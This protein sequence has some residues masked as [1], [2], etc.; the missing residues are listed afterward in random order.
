M[1]ICCVES[2]VYSEMS[3]CTSLLVVPSLF[4]NATGVTSHECAEL[5]YHRP[6]TCTGYMFADTCEIC[7]SSTKT[8]AEGQEAL[9]TRPMCHG[10]TCVA[11]YGDQVDVRHDT[12]IY[13][14]S[15]SNKVVPY[16]N[17]DAFESGQSVNLNLLTPF[18][19]NLTIVGPGVISATLPLQLG[20]DVTIKN[21]VEFRQ[22]SLPGT[23]QAALVISKGGRVSLNGFVGSHYAKAFVTV[24]PQKALGEYVAISKDSEVNFT[25][26]DPRVCA[27]AFS[28]T[29]GSVSVH[30]A[31]NCF[32]VTQDLG[33][34]ER[35]LLKETNTADVNIT[36][37]NLTSLLNDFGTEYL[38]QFVDGPSDGDS[39]PTAV[40]GILSSVAFS[41]TLLTAVFQQRYLALL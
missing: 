37:V 10:N 24:A 29:Q 33:G 26:S 25:G 4:V 12:I 11:T 15:D 21:N 3:C 22:C 34:T 28:H 32:T 39:T 5:C 9:V 27:A 30:C 36:N 40:A 1:Y 38:I 17:E 41:F 23:V 19:R 14:S 8:C 31:N 16:S 7:E 35:L 20:E 2:Y 18:P 13:I 6:E